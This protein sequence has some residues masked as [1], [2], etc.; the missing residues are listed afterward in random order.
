MTQYETFESESFP[1]EFEEEQPSG[2]ET[3]FGEFEQ[4]E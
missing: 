2:F 3:E 1:G 4:F